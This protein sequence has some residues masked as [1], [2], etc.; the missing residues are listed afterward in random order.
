MSPAID[1][2][3]WL[4]PAQAARHIGVTPAWIRTLM[5]R[6]RVQYVATPLGRL[7]NPDSLASM[8]AKR[9]SEGDA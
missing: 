3:G 8:R 7:V 1:T 6:D 5:K 4:T 9:R 2:T